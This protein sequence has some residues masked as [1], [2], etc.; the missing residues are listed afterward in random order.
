MARKH[1]KTKEELIREFA[2]KRIIWKSNP[3]LFFQ[4]VLGI[5]LPIHQKKIIETICKNNLITIKSANSVGKTYIVAALA[6]WY[7]FT[8]VSNMPNEDTIVIITAPVFSQVRR[9]IFANIR[10]FADIADSYVKKMFGENC[11]F[12][13][14]NFSDSANVAEYWFNKKS[15]IMGIATDNCNAISGIHAKNLMIIFD[16]AQGIPPSTFSGF[17]GVF[18]GGKYKFILLGN[19]TLPEGPSGNYYDSFKKDSPFKKI[20]ISAF[21]TPNF[22]ESNIN[23]EDMLCPESAP[24]NWRK[25]LD[26]RYGTNYEQALLRGEVGLWETELL[27]KMPYSMINPI[28]AF[29]TLQKNGMNPDSYE[30]L[31]RVLA[32]FPSDSSSCVISAKDLETSMNNYSSPNFHVAGERVMGLDIS[33]GTGRDYNAICIRDGNKVIYLDRFNNISAPDFEEL[34]VS[35]Y[36]EYKCD[37]CI[38]E[39]DGV[40]KPVYDHL[41]VR[42]DITVY[43]MQVGAGAGLGDDYIATYEEEEENKVL[44]STYN[45]KR[46]ELWFN[47]R[48]L[49]NKYTTEKPVLLPPNSKLKAHLLC[50]NWKKNATGKIQVSSKD[51]M[52]I[53]LKESPDLGDSVL[54]AFAP[55]GVIDEVSKYNVGITTISNAKWD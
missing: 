41:S 32:E 18:Q 45:R 29:T 55:I 19:T 50:A 24:N 21:E 4:E 44:K 23:L 8:N 22:I 9:S 13:S 15:Y 16:E 31:T 25:K 35:L 1:V 47:L 11:S 2:R 49:L 12:L 54:M 39:R 7:F 20:S 28:S 52:K 6:F 10:N 26:R 42:D 43:P 38:I 51:E 33:G 37:Y 5:K 46:D 14:K 34:V 36:R 30:F 17:E 40:G 48:N 27:D 53:K 3:A